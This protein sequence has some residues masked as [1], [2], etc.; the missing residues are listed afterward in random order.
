MHS[1][2][3]SFMRSRFHWLAIAILHFSC[4]NG[5][6]IIGAVDSFYREN[7]MEIFSP[8]FFSA[9]LAIVVI[10]LVLAGDNAIVI[11]LAARNVPAQLQKRAILWG[12]V[13]AIVVR[14]SL[15]L[16]VVSLLAVPGLL[17]AGG[18]IL[19][20]IAYKLLLPEPEDESGAKISSA[21]SFWGAIRTIVFAD[22]I[23]GL[24]NVL[25]VAGAAHGSYLLVVLGLLISVPIMIG[26]STL[27]LKFVLRF[28]AFVYVGAGVLAWTAVKMMSAEPLLKDFYADHR[29][30][31]P[32]MFFVVVI[33][34]LWAGFVKNHRRL[35]S[36]ITSRIAKFTSR[37]FAS[38]FVSQPAEGGNTMEK[39]LVPVDGTPNSQHAVRHVIN[40]FMKNRALEVHVL[41][42][43]PAFSRYVAR[44]VSKKNIRDYHREQ[45]NVAL[46]PVRRVLD[47]FGVP[48]S[49][50]IEVGKKAEIIANEARR[51]RCG[52]IVMSTARKNSLTRMIEDSTT[53][54]VLEL[55]EVPVEIIA[56]DSVSAMERYG[57]PAGIGATVA[58][59]LMALD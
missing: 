49:V 19:V 12:T 46:A 14:T 24:D 39:V 43:Q 11:A 2:A 26:G 52:Q 23:M 17:F 47:Q 36:R 51:L 40:L 48:Y 34:V 10:D 32:L 20:W 9:L 5:V 45:S 7:G 18:A 29:L 22:L 28:P 4:F 55:T 35:E 53:N 50:H 25:A 58:A 38:P 37:P 31:V 21:N 16:V 1:I 13:G 3:F 41:N 54:R 15:T 27:M 6:A 59:M 8:G 33:G 57:I 44:F 42:V 56:G 30:V